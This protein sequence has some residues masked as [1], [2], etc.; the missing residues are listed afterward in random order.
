MKE[1]NLK[2]IKDFKVR[3]ALDATEENVVTTIHLMNTHLIDKDAALDQSS[4]G[5]NDF[6][7]DGWYYDIKTNHLF[8]YQSKLSDTKG[9]VL[10]GLKDLVTA[11]NFLEKIIIEK[12]IGKVPT[13]K[14]IYNLYIELSKK[15]ENLRIISFILLSPLNENDLID[16]PEWDET[17]KQIRDSK[18]FSTIYERSGKISLSA[19]EYNFEKAISISTKKYSIKK[20]ESSVIKLKDKS[21]LEIT[22]IPIYSL[23]QLYRQR[24]DIL[25]HKNIRLSL[26]D[27]KDTKNRVVTPMENTLN[28]ICSG[29]LSPNIFSFYHVGI[30]ISAT[31]NS[32]DSATEIE[33]ETPYIING[34]QTITIADHFLRELENKKNANAIEKFKQI[35]VLAKVVIGT[36]DEELKEIT[37]SNNRQNP[38][39]NWQLFSN[40]PIHIEIEYSLL[41]CGIL[42]ERQKGRFKLLNKVDIVK[43]YSNTNNTFVTVEI[44]GQIIALFQGNYQW[45][46]KPSEIFVN[47]QN[48]DSIFTKEIQKYPMDIVLCYNLFKAAKTGLT[49]YLHLPT[50]DNEQTWFVFNK[51]VVKALV[52][53]TALLYYYQRILPEF[54]FASW[55]YQKASPNL[56]DEFEKIYT[57]FI[58]KTKNFYLTETQRSEEVSF[59]KLKTFFENQ[60]IELGIDTETSNMPFTDRAIEWVEANTPAN[61]SLENVSGNL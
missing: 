27:Y 60:F 35:N 8:I 59:K 12:E 23:V 52:H 26:Y 7:I 9:L 54:K 14:A 39:D 41:N 20:L 46:A 5:S 25:F 45:A 56:V 31:T 51:P 30:T 1:N 32:S 10:K 44:L 16:D 53:R 3:Y 21:N 38:I 55:L 34:C 17:E 42:Y 57:K 29:Q 6:G 36:T 48:H 4:L 24:G 43:N 22:F 11:L 50:H 37:N 61:I 19:Q 47:K 40:D 15:I 49:N 58:S 13:N 18:L 33:L 2:I 28:Q